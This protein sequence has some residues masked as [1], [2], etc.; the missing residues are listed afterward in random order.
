MTA[1]TSP[2]WTTS[3][4]FTRSSDTVPEPSATTGISIFM[5]SRITSVS[6]S[7]TASPCATTTFQTF[8]TIS[9]RTSVATRA[10][11][12]VTSPGIQPQ[13]ES[14]TGVVGLA[15]LEEGSHA[16]GSVAGG[17]QQRQLR[18]HGLQRRR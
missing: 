2:S 18:L 16:F 10:P 9:A 13:G 12:V 11:L 3:P 17:G 14:A 7:S 1:I 4:S 5:D 15:L 8:A 6:P